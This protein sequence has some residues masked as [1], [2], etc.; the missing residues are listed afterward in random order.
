MRKTEEAP[1][2]LKVP[3]GDQHAKTALHGLAEREHQSVRYRCQ[4]GGESFVHEP[5]EQGAALDARVPA[6]V[7]SIE[8][9]RIPERRSAVN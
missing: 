1:G 8:E 2:L 5:R 3:G 4:L 6:I 7:L 9:H